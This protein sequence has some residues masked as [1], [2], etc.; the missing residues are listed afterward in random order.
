VIRASDYDP[1][2]APVIAAPG[3]VF[4]VVAHL[5]YADQEHF[6]T[7]AVDS[8]RRL[9]AIHETAVGGTSAALVEAGHVVKLPLLVGASAVLVAH[10]HPSQ[11]KRF[12]DDDVRMTHALSSAT[13]CVGLTLLDHVLV[14]RTGWLSFLEEYGNIAGR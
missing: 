8:A 12:S 4:R 14:T 6:V 2:D 10:N 3:D 1:T 13:R 5:Q 7:L 11:S 9:R